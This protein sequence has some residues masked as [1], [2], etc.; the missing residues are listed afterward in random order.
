VPERGCGEHRMVELTTLVVWSC[1]LRVKFWSKVGG[2]GV[3]AVLADGSECH[4][5]DCSFRA[6]A[7]GY[8]RG[9]RGCLDVLSVQTHTGS[10]WVGDV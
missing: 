2:E 4:V 6:K 5:T 9:S 1:K 10:K 7:P 3:R 8:V